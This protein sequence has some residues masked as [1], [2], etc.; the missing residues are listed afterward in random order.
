MTTE[1]LL[2]YLHF[3]AIL[4]LVVFMSSE[5][6]L[7]RSEWLNADVVRRLVR[8]DAIYGA[9]SAAVLLTGVARTLWGMKG[10][11]WFWSQP[12]LW[13]KLGLFVVIGLLSIKPTLAFLRWRKTL[14]A[15]GALP[16]PDEVR[17]IR[18]IVMIEAHLLV[19]IPLAAVFLARGIGVC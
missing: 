13:T 2:A 3:A 14:E 9:A 18:R 10:A 12:L 1:A 5:A 15:S 19:L 17:A 8:V 7:C 16:P 11:G 6:A 4:T